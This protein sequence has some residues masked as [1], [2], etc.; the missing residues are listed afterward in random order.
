MVQRCPTLERIADFFTK[1]LEGALFYK[2]H[3]TALGVNMDNAESYKNRC[4]EILKKCN[5]LDNKTSN[6]FQD[7]VEKNSI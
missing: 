6:K 7:C 2:F 3:N 1:L 4:L 5:L